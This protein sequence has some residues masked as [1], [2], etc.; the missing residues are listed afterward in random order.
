II[1]HTFVTLRTKSTISEN[2][3]AYH[4]TMTRVLILQ[5]GVPTLFALVPIAICF[6]FFF[7]DWNGILVIPI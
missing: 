3:K 1:C 5:S 4:R 2:M 7:F 6:N